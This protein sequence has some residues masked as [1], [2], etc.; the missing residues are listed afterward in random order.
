MNRK[1]LIADDDWDNRMI[2]KEILEISGFEVLEA[3]D[4]AEAID[5]VAKEHPDLLLLDLSMPK[6]NGW[7]VA[8]RLREKDDYAKM[9]IV[10]FTAHAIIGDELRAKG[11]GCDDYLS[12]PCAPQDVLKKI[13]KWLN[14]ESP[15]D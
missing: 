14:Q 10:A 2:V 1:V 3:K 7:E 13:E 5:M 4:G 11:S 9:P 8:K 15:H 6:I 12:K